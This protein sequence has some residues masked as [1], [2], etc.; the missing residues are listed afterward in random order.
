[1]HHAFHPFQLGALTKI[2]KSDTPVLQKGK[3]RRRQHHFFRKLRRLFTHFLG[4]TSHGSLHR[5]AGFDA[6]EHQIERIGP[7]PP[8]RRLP[9]VHAVRDID[10]GG[11]KADIS[12]QQ[13]RHQPKY[14]RF[15]GEVPENEN[16]GECHGQEDERQDESGGEKSVEGIL[17]AQAGRA[18][19][20]HRILVGK[21]FAK[22]EFFNDAP[23]GLVVVATKRC[24]A[25]TRGCRK[26]LAF[27]ASNELPFRRDRFHTLGEVFSLQ[28]W[29]DQR[30]ERRKDS[31]SDESSD[32]RLGIG[33]ARKKI[34]CHAAT[35]NIEIDHLAHDEY[36][37]QHP[38]PGRAQNDVP[39]QVGEKDREIVRRGEMHEHHDDEWQG[40]DDNRGRFRFHRKGVHLGA[41]FFAVTQYL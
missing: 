15:V 40:A 12:E 30:V 9:L 26:P 22:I 6:D 28:K 1:M 37:D 29:H 31:Q 8:Y 13:H 35:S 36:P 20:V 17:R 21:R 33:E 10:V 19:F 2:L 23:G 18:Q 4:N 11:V 5:D 16:P 3:F 24:P 14:K 38:K 27:A 7:G 25:V 34:S 39:A 32:D 41:H